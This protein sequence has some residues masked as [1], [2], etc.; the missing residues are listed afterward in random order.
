MGWRRLKS[1][2]RRK[3]G[4][5]WRTWKTRSL[6]ENEQPGARYT[7]H[8]VYVRRRERR[9]ANAC[10]WVVRGKVYKEWKRATKWPQP[11]VVETKDR[12]CKE[13]YEWERAETVA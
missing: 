8:T 11:P 2:R 3:R 4:G 10:N 13:K 12:K 6:Q 5:N 1:P 9:T 7:E